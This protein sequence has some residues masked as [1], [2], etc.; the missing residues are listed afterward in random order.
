M[1]IDIILWLPIAIIGIA[2]I[3]MSCGSYCASQKWS[4]PGY[5]W[6]LIIAGLG[7][8]LAIF[9]YLICL[10]CLEKPSIIL[11]PLFV[12]IGFHILCAIVVFYLCNKEDGK[13]IKIQQ[14]HAVNLTLQPIET[15][16]LQKLAA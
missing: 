13:Q 9:I 15:E 3:W 1:M 2:G 6:S 8:P 11:A 4:L 12:L 10:L 16:T 14:N 7:S 5:L